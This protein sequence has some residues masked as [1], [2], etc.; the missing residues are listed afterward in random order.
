MKEHQEMVKALFKSGD[1]T[2]GNMTSVES[3]LIHAVMG[4]SGESGEILDAIKKHTIYKKPLDLEN[5]IEEL[6][7]IEFY[8][9]ALRDI[10]KITREQTLEANIKKLSVRYPKGSYSN[11]DAV[12]RKDKVVS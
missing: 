6:G 7:D 5:V 8:L 4:V 3:A 10:L 9:E 12:E 11:E 1:E 2:L